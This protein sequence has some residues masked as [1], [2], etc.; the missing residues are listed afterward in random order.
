VR[1]A[2]F[3]PDSSIDEAAAAAY[4]AS[5]QATYGEQDES[6]S[7]AI[8]GMHRTDTIDIVT[9]VDGE[10]WVVMDEGETCL[11]AGDSLVQRGTR[12]AWQ[13][14]SDKPCTVSTVMMRVQPAS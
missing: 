7:T 1:V 3:P 5:M 9:V 12:H 6:A 11:R 14:R 10:I 2:V 4:K 8:P 13:N